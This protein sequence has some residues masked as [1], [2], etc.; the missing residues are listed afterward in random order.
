MVIGVYGLGR[1]GAFWATH[2]ARVG[3]VVGYSRS[4][5]PV[6][7]GYR[8]APENDVLAADVVV[9]CVA[10]SALPEVLQQVA[11]RIRPEALV[12]DTCSIKVHPTRSMLE[13]LP[14]P[15]QILAT[16]PMFGPDSGRTGIDGLPIILCPARATATTVDRWQGL[17]AALGLR[18]VRMTADQHDREAARTQGV[19]HFIGRVLAEMQL[20]DSPIATTGYRGLLSIIEHTCNDSWQL[21]SDLQ[22]LNPYTAPV[23]DNL[24]EAFRRVMGGLEGQLDADSGSH[25]P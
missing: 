13:Q 4:S 15:T 11:S 17:F 23:R 6:P 9:F 22:R 7:D 25:L 14:E 1:F 2:L 19:T 5:K 10:I 24:A 16:H 12:M 20:G 21:F 18:V 8:L 3:D